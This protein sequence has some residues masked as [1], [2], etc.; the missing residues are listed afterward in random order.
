MSELTEI[1]IALNI[2]KETDEVLD[3]KELDN[4]KIAFFREQ[5]RKN[6]FF[7]QEELSEQYSEAVTKY[8]IFP[9]LAY[10]DE[11]IMFR[12]EQEGNS[13]NWNLLQQEYYD[14]KDGGEYVFDII[15]SLLSDT[16]Y[17]QVCY[18]IIF[19]I[20]NSDF[21]GKYYSN[22]YDSDFLSYKKQINKIISENNSRSLNIIDATK[23]SPPSRDIKTAS[24]KKYL[25]G[26]AIPIVLFGI[27]VFV[28]SF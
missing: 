18:K 2:I 19:F 24:Y 20:L 23:P 28:F 3:T 15:D 7:L 11:K 14:R 25:I 5:V 9:L 27:S 12:Y 16:I 17:P 4:E 22:I 13:F 10:V 26:A 6:V 1:E 8:A 21:S